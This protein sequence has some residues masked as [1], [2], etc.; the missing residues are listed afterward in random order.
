LRRRDEG[1]GVETGPAVV[2]VITGD[3]GKEI[4]AGLP[5]S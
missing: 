5:K 2:L 1:G 4:V 3:A